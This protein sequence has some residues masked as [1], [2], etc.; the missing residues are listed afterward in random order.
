MSNQRWKAKWKADDIAFHQPQIHPHLI[1]FWPRLALPEGAT[2]LVPLCGKSLDLGW[3]HQQGHRVIGVELSHIAIAAYFAERGLQPQRQRLGRFQ[4]YWAG[5][6]ELWCGDLFDLRREDLG[7]VA[8]VYD[9]AALTALPAASRGHYVRQ[10]SS[11][12]AVG[13]Q[14]L[15]LT[16]ESADEPA[17]MAE[18]AR[19]ATD[20]AD[21]GPADAEHSPDPEVLALYQ[22][23][24]AIALWFGHTC[25]KLDPEYPG[26]PASLLAEKVY[27]LGP[28]V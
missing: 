3:L 26:L 25:L 21:A 15:L 17:A 14:M 12:L 8:A 16:T 2:V 20:Q 27:H 4:R 19:A 11:L 9:C 1:R 28:R 10:L 6:L 5:T 24:F 7:D 22:S 18:V 13:G 23:R